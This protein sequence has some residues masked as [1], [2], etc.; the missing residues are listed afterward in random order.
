MR[1]QVG[2]VDLKGWVLICY[3]EI[4]HRRTEDRAGPRRAQDRARCSVTRVDE[5]HRPAHA[6]A[7]ITLGFCCRGGGDRAPALQQSARTHAATFAERTSRK[8]GTRAYNSAEFRNVIYA[9][10]QGARAFNDGTKA[11]AIIALYEAFSAGGMGPH[12]DPDL[13]HKWREGLSEAEREERERGYRSWFSQLRNRVALVRKALNPR[14][15]L[16]PRRRESILGADPLIAMELQ[17][18]FKERRGLGLAKAPKT[19][20]IK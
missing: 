7:S 13:P 14:S 11:P 6:R 15:A 20:R 17:R 3:G 19:S 9:C 16:S 8:P 1:E 18:P 12:P 4:A 10:G 2:R 5:L